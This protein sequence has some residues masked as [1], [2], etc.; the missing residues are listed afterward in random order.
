MLEER[1]YKAGIR[2]FGG[3]EAF[4]FDELRERVVELELVSIEREYTCW[5]W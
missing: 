3:D 2:L 1:M 4:D 5:R